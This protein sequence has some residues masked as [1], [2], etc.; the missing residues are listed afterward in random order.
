MLAKL[1]LH[2]TEVDQISSILMFIHLQYPQSMFV[3]LESIILY[4]NKT[5]IFF[6]FR[7]G[8]VYWTMMDSVPIDPDLVARFKDKTMAIVGYESDQVLT[9]KLT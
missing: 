4:K 3:L 1:G 7:Y 9:I 6:Y 2:F 5:N 8:E